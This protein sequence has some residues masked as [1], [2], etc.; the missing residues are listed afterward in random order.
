MKATDERLIIITITS[1]EAQ[2]LQY[3]I[4]WALMLLKAQNTE[5]KDDKLIELREILDDMTS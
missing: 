4:S 5:A 1:A 3:E 2:Q